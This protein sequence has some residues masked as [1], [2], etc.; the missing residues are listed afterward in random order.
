ML[1][2]LTLAEVIPQQI[3]QHAGG[4]TIYGLDKAAVAVGV[5]LQGGQGHHHLGA[6]LRTGIARALVLSGQPLQRFI[7]GGVHR[8]IAA[9]VVVGRQ[10]LQ[11]HG[12]H[13]HVAVGF[14]VGAGAP[15]AIL[16]LLGQ[17]GLYQ[18][19]AVLGIVAAVEGQQA[20]YQAVDIRFT[21]IG[22]LHDILVL[23]RRQQVF[24]AHVGGVLAD[25]GK[26]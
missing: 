14:C 9:L 15:A 18:P 2:A 26:G 11:R 19:V 3:A 16:I 10:R 21:G 12:G 20:E 1:K 4:R 5:Q 25:G 24:A 7:D 17:D 6:A 23:Q 22:D 13:V 8:G